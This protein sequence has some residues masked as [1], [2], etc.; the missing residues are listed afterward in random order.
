MSLSLPRRLLT[1]LLLA[2]IGLTPACGG[3]DAKADDGK[4]D[5]LPKSVLGDDVLGL[6]VSQEKLTDTVVGTK[7]TYLDAIGLYSLRK[8]DLLQAT[9]QVSRFK[10]DAKYAKSKF[11]QSILQQIGTTV[12]RPFRMAGRT[13]YLTTGKRQNVAVWFTG[14]YAYVLST[15][16]EYE[17]PRALLRR[18]LEIK[19]DD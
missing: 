11:R 6:S 18:A 5:V 12:P 9:L 10:T 4:I 17:A 3:S 7:R 2:I 16:Q 14:R 1:L 8:G 19:L 15:R 13:V